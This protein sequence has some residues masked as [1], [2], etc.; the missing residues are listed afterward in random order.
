MEEVYINKYKKSINIINCKTGEIK[1]NFTEMPTKEEIKKYG[2]NAIILKKSIYYKSKS[3]NNSCPLCFKDFKEKKK[4]GVLSCG[5]GYCIN[6]NIYDNNK[7]ISCSGIKEWLKTKKS[8]PLCRKDLTKHN[9][10][11]W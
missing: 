1:K 2:K 7:D 9:I 4:I 10:R 6:E 8:C 3:I 11:P 5:H